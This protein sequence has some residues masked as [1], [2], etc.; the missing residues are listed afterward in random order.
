MKKICIITLFVSVIS[1]LIACSK[2]NV[3]KNVTDFQI[4]DEYFIYDIGEEIVS[5]DV[6]EEGKLYYMVY[7]EQTEEIETDDGITHINKLPECNIKVLD[8]NGNLINTYSLDRFAQF[9]CVGKDGIYYMDSKSNPSNR[10]LYKYSFDTLK[11]E[12]L[13][14]VNG[15]PLIKNIAYSDGKLFFLGENTDY[16]G[17]QISVENFI[18]N[19][20]RVGYVD[21][22]NNTYND[23]DIDFPIAQSKTV[24]GNLMIYAFDEEKGYYFIELDTSLMKFGDR[25]Y[26][27][28]DT[29]FTFQIINEKNDFLFC[30]LKDNA[31]FTLAIGNISNEK[32]DT[33]LIPDFQGDFTSIL[34]RNGYTYS[35]TTNNKQI[36]RAR[37]D[38]FN[39]RSETITM[40]STIYYNMS[41]PFGCGYT[42]KREYLSNEEM[43]LSMLS[44]DDSYDIYYLNTYE[45]FSHNVRSKGS[46]YPLNE[47]DGVREYLDSCFPYVKEAA[48]DENGDIWMIPVSM[49][50]LQIMYNEN[51]CKENGIEFSNNMNLDDLAKILNKVKSDNTMTDKFLCNNV[52]LIN[53]LLYQYTR[54]YKKFDT[55]LFK[56]LSRTIKDNFYGESAYGKYIVYSLTKSMDNRML[57]AIYNDNSY[58]ID[59]I[60]NTDG[61]RVCKIPSITKDKS[62]IA[63]CYFLCVNSSSK[64]LKT[65]L[66][67]ISSLCKYLQTKEYNLMLNDWSFT[68]KSILMDDMYEIYSNGYIQFTYP[69]ELYKDDF[70][71][72]MSGEIELEKVI[73]E[74]NRRMDIYLNE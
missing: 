1:F 34:Y 26:N 71:K 24:D 53:N 61:L 69:N 37:V 18:Y 41:T 63:D 36:L 27:D 6:D 15:Y 8:E 50:M 66:K 44:Q 22:S 31:S 67:Y 16:I 25:I 7:K 19:G 73:E 55:E 23:L 51:F 57:F 17:Y 59:K 70:F 29:I 43:A 40:L 60:M 11:S 72:Y 30:K 38:Y 58:F 48:T 52:M 65:V 35:V 12:K 42:I 39:R 4:K 13:C 14:D 74:S 3:D 28:L 5:Y 32:L 33:D 54:E 56:N 62:N 45:D 47:V 64:K 68:D 46:F 21:L 10:T 20:E 9:F 49:R 2:K